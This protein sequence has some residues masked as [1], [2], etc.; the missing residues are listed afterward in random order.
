MCE[1]KLTESKHGFPRAESSLSQ[2]FFKIG[3]LKYVLQISQE[4][5]CVVVWPANLLKI[6]FNTRVFLSNLWN[7]WECFFYYRAPPVAAFQEHIKERETE[8]LEMRLLKF[9]KNQAKA[10]QHPEDELLLFK[11]YWL[12]SWT[13]ASKVIG[14]ILKNV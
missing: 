10:K 5:T 12:S 8:E 4:N 6:D 13:L 9:A 3:V 14:N 2:M 1:G 11:N 7:F